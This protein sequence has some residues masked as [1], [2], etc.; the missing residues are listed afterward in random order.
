M[1]RLMIIGGSGLLGGH[2]IQAAGHD[3]HVAATYL[4]H[5]IDIPGCTSIKMDI[6]DSLGTE[7]TILNERPDVII[8]SAAQRNVDYCEENRDEVW[9]INVEGVRNVAIA[10]K[11]CD[12]K[13]I[14]ISTDLV[15]DGIK[16]RYV[17]DDQTNPINHYGV[18]KLAGEKEVTGLSE[19]YAI[20]RVSVLYDTNPFGH[21]TNFVAWV[22]DSL[23]NG[24]PISLFT[25]Q[26]RNATYIKNACDA[27]LE[28][29]RKDERGIFHV[30][31]RTCENRYDIGMNIAEIFGF[32]RELI[33]KA[34]SDNSDWLAKRPNKC[35]LLCEKMETRL[36][37]PAVGIEDGLRA[38]KMEMEQKG[39]K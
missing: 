25:D 26:Y 22:I 33:S 6:T 23:E 2:L 39:R 19:D 10:S 3:F 21:T 37:I 16:G 35:C 29:Y 34:T 24:T 30:A 9:R 5:P 4:G 38:M 32:D 11:K 7:R 18:T 12:T 13:L 17:E 27:L 14:Y 15:F 36:G 20:A 28:I 1:D 8:L 31:G